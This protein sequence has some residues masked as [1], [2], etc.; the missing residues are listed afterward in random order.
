M[1]TQ[2]NN[3]LPTELSKLFIRARQANRLALLCCLLFAAFPAIARGQAVLKTVSDMVVVTDET[4]KESTVYIT[5]ETSGAIYSSTVAAASAENPGRLNSADFKLFYVTKPFLQPSA[6]AYANGK[7]IVCDKSAPAI[8][9]IDTTT[10]SVTVLYVG[11]TAPRQPSRVA[12]SSS[13]R[14]AISNASGELFVYDR[15]GKVQTTLG[16][17]F[18]NPVRLAFAGEDLIILEKQGMMFQAKSLE[19]DAPV[20]TPFELPAKVATNTS[21]VVDFAFLNGVYYLAGENQVNA[22]IRS[23]GVA[24]PLFPEPK[25]SVSI[26]AITVNGDNIVV[27]DTRNNALWEM[28]RPIPVTA[29]FERGSS[30]SLISLYEYLIERQGLPIRQFVSSRDYTSFAELLIDQRIIFS[31]STDSTNQLVKFVCQLNQ[32]LCGATAANSPA[33]VSQT[34]H[35]GQ[36]VLLP[37]LTYSEVIGYETRNLGG[38]T[39]KQYLTSAFAPDVGARFTEDVLWELNQLSRS[40]T[41]EIQLQKLPG[42]VLAAPPRRSLVPGTIVKVGTEQDLIL[43]SVNNCL[44]QFGYGPKDFKLANSF[45]NTVKGGA[46]MGQVPR[47]VVNAA[48]TKQLKQ[49]EIDEVQ[50]EMVGPTVEVGDARAIANAMASNSPT[51]ATADATPDPSASPSP[52]P[53][54]DLKTC[55]GRYF[56]PSSYLVVDAVKVQSGRYKFFKNGSQIFPRAADFKR[57]GLLGEVDQTGVWS[58]L[59]K[60]PYYVAYRVSRWNDPSVLQ[61]N[62]TKIETNARLVRPGGTQD[63]FA[64]KEGSLLLPFVRRWQVTFL[65]SDSQLTDQSSEFNK[66]KGNLKFTALRAEETSRASALRLTP[67]PLVPD[68]IPIEAVTRNR[69]ALKA[70][71]NFPPVP[72]DVDVEI[73]IAE[74]VCNTDKKHTDFVDAAGDNAW[75][76]E[77]G[78]TAPVACDSIEPANP[79][80]VKSPTQFAETDHGTH[81]AGLIGA[82]ANSIAPGLIPS[83]KLFLV[84]T[85]SPDRIVPAVTNAISRRVFIFNFSIG[86]EVDDSDLHDL[87]KGTWTNQLFIV[88]VDNDGADLTTSK[89]PLVAFMGDVT[90]NMIGVGSSITAAG[91]QYVLGDWRNAETI[92]RGSSY[93]KQFVHLVA[94]GQGVYS[95]LSGNYYG[96][97][98]GASQAAPQVTATAALLF[99]GGIETPSRIKARLIYTSDWY[100]QFRGKVWGGFL[101]AD[102]ALFQPRKNLIRTE[103]LPQQIDAITLDENSDAMLT[104]KPGKAKYYDPTAESPVN[105]INI[106]FAN[107]L[108]ITELPTKGSFRVIFLDQGKL[109][110]ILNAVIS[111][112]FPCRRLE[113]WNSTAFAVTPCYPGGLDASQ[114]SDYVA[115][116]PS[117]A[118][119]F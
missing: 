98:T 64:L 112:K 33:L 49:L 102:R 6:I 91:T 44:V 103:S 106:P 88:A 77:P 89:N 79:P 57:L 4:K 31:D 116:I 24:I 108:R 66:L 87:M 83:A 37:D 39:V 109:R 115:A 53:A 81:V 90:D 92:E 11:A 111:G 85:T 75:L 21:R 55:L 119:K 110:I 99:A 62:T 56:G 117:F 46:A 73:G 80:K 113:R 32:E 104:V 70:E 18:D 16:R 45:K 50:F 51:P 76:V 43:G 68:D 30:G 15:S 86:L 65:L 96:A 13:G 114:I 19:S 35:A 69:D 17:R 9:E 12:V 2:H 5:D 72:G 34:I 93:G 67:A 1:A 36:T 95:T 3:V 59:V 61:N 10:K 84:D 63:I 38:Q 101:N 23:K 20:I 94:P 82:R 78:A 7:L 28:E 25:K 27:N 48:T 42:A 54:P 22:F 60:N 100:E 97:A 74:K 107:I 118:V 105:G 40:D 52:S 41:L 58:L 26:A 47:S 8:F 29:S 71:I 14:L